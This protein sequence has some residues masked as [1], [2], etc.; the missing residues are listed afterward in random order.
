MLQIICNP[1]FVIITKFEITN[2]ILRRNRAA[3]KNRRY[4]RSQQI[5]INVREQ[6]PTTDPPIRG[7]D[8][9]MLAPFKISV[10]L[11]AIVIGVLEIPMLTIL[12][13]YTTVI[14]AITQAF[15]HATFRHKRHLMRIFTPRGKTTRDKMRLGKSITVPPTQATLTIHTTLPILLVHALLVRYFTKIPAP[16]FSLIPLSVLMR[17][18]S[19]RANQSALRRNIAIC[20]RVPIGNHFLTLLYRL[21]SLIY[22]GHGIEVFYQ[23]FEYWWRCR[24]AF[25]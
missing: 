11:D 1:I 3:P 8:F 24:R 5:T 18:S 23:E 25:A 4:K 19:N 15:R 20:R 17:D 16:L 9:I 2:S 6:P 13:K 22:Y 12:A 7:Q 10:N 21:R 14:H